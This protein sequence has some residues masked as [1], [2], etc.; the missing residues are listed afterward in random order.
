MTSDYTIRPMN[1]EDWG[2]YRQIDEGIFP[3]NLTSEESFNKL[4]E[5]E[6]FYALEVDDDMAGVLIVNRFGDHEGHL[7]RIGVAKDYQGNGYGKALMEHALEWFRDRDCESVHLY[8]QD[9]N[10]VAQSLYT[11][12]GFE[13]AGTSW[14]YFVPFDSINP[15]GKCTCRDISEE[16]IEEVGQR[17]ETE[18]PAA[19]IMRYLYAG[20]YHILV[21][22]GHSG[23]LKGACRFSPNFPGCFPFLIEDVSCFDDFVAGVEPFGLPKFNYVRVTFTD[24]PRLADLCENRDY[25]LHQ[26]LYKMRLESL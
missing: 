24:Y 26:R 2:A 3:N 14:H 13:I 5:K 22:K 10:N 17:Y 19:Q 7:Q 18:L 21:L 6:G 20:R 12:F 15:K 9:F 25:E 23:E 1:S 16:E 4:L 11:Q 8:T